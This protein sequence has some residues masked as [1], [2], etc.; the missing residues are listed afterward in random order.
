MK[1]IIKN[2][3]NVF[4]LEVTRR[5]LGSDY[6]SQVVKLMKTRKIRVVLD[7]GANVGQFASKIRQRGYS[8][9][10]ISFEPLKSARQK[11]ITLANNDNN[12][13]V[14]DRAAVGDING[15]VSINVSRNL[16]SSSIMPMLDAHSK[17]E[18][19]SVYIDCETTPLITLDSVSDHYLAEFDKC[20]IKIDTQGYESQV[21]DGADETLNNVS[22]VMCELSLIPL[23]SGQ[24][25]WR[26]MITK[27]DKKGFELWSIERGFTDK[28]NGRTLQVDAVFVKK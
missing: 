16:S 22:A 8:G 12:W 20:F 2:I 13:F 21:L 6:L 25:L 3:F 15:E 23:Y 4:G 24:D 27:L 14:H 19:N 10:I 11:L 5:S 18:P 28:T 7:V 9:K 1:K 17:V 26:D